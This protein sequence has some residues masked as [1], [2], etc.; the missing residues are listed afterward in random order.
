MKY[1]VGI[2][3]SLLLGLGPVPAGFAADCPGS[4]TPV[5]DV[6]LARAATLCLVDAERAAAGAPPLAG[7]PRLGAS[8]QA[9]A[10]RLVAGHFFGHVDPAGGSL[11]DRLRSA[12]YV[13]RSFYVGGENLAMMNGGAT[14]RLIVAAWMASAGH[15]ANLLDP[16]YRE[17]GVGV[18]VGTPTAAQG[19]TFVQH[20][21]ARLPQ[22]QAG[23]G[24]SPGT[25]TPRAQAPKRGSK[26]GK[27]KSP[28]NHRHDPRRSGR[29]P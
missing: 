2:A 7:D 25:G 23:A 10:G 18:S 29:A 8:A 14:P 26:A 1:V 24:G 3:V 27:K 4:D 9:Y 28:R 20:F 16:R 11:M 15:R 22:A 12:G 19:A 21:G 13:D 6:E 17:T 5:A